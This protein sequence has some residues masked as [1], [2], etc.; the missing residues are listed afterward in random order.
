[1]QLLKH[2]HGAIMVSHC[3][4]WKSPYDGFRVHAIRNP[5]TIQTQSQCFL[6]LWFPFNRRFDP[7]EES[8]RLQCTLEARRNPNVS[9]KPIRKHYLS[10]RSIFLILNESGE[11]PAHRSVVSYMDESVRGLHGSVPCSENVLF[12]NM[13]WGVI[14]WPVT[15]PSGLSLL[16]LTCPAIV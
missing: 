15:P 13:K 16:F 12:L 9:P 3:C 14:T 6:N 5:S 10:Q 4:S 11:S 7:P 8:E 1:M 2:V